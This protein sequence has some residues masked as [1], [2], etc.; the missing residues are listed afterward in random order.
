MSAPLLRRLQLPRELHSEA[1]GRR[2]WCSTAAGI[3]TGASNG[4]PTVGI[5]DP[6][7]WSSGRRASDGFL[8]AERLDDGLLVAET[9][10]LP[11]EPIVW[12]GDVAVSLGPPAEGG[13]PEPSGVPSA[14]AR[15]GSPRIRL[16]AVTPRVEVVWSVNKTLAQVECTLPCRPVGQRTFE[17]E[18][19]DP[20]VRLEASESGS[21][22]RV[23]P[24]AGLPPIIIRFNGEVSLEGAAVWHSDVNVLD[25]SGP[26]GVEDRFSPGVFV[27]R[28]PESAKSLR[29][30]VEVEA[31]LAHAGSRP[32]DAQAAPPT[33]R[34]RLLD[35]LSAPGLALEEGWAPDRVSG[36][37]D[38]HVS[39]AMSSIGGPGEIA[40]DD[41]AL[42]LGRTCQLLLR[43]LRSAWGP[44][45]YRGLVEDCFAPAIRSMVDA[46]LAA[47]PAAAAPAAAP[48]A[49]APAA[50]TPAAA[51]P[52][53][54][55]ASSAG[56]E[57]PGRTAAP[58]L[59]AEGVGELATA[60]GA[61]DGG[62]GDDLVP[63]AARFRGARRWYE[64]LASTPA[65]PRGA[66]SVEAGALLHQLFIF[67]EQ[68]CRMVS[69]GVRGESAASR[70]LEA[71]RW[72]QRAF[73]LSTP[74]RLADLEMD[75]V[76]PIGG[77]ALSMR[78]GMLVA[79][80]LE[81]APLDE[82]QR[83]AVVNAV[84]ERLLTPLGVRSIDR[85]DR[86]FR[87]ESPQDGA[88][89]P[90]LLGVHAEAAIRAFGRD[91]GR[92]D[93]EE[94]LLA[95]IDGAPEA[96]AESPGGGVT[97]IGVVTFP[98]ASG[99]SIRAFRLLTEVLGEDRPR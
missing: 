97:P 22:V 66:A 96:W 65:D 56:G 73:W 36:W 93:F 55:G 6:V 39:A 49:A 86:G 99:E 12:L 89:W 28:L 95:A 88:V 17:N 68:L 78:A 40:R 9:A 46:I 74:R 45:T 59:G 26:L 91:L 87:E 51:T 18:A 63:G 75:R 53:E 8:V 47:D 14:P 82:M 72:F 42:W 16:G 90:W 43:N 84:D 2:R 50:A 31:D 13:E 19:L 81:G 76:D 32:T 71:R 79:A 11:G 27:I 30:T 80:A 4:P 85:A 24:Y 67:E 20:R 58:D 3:S 33:T 7:L 29:M 38:Q 23:R 77:A 94:S 54:P 34:D 64:V 44:L 10:D 69:D 21:V 1:L 60:E 98:P 35:I 70:A 48:A 61:E 92:L 83:R 41:S 52:F 62:A 25:K 15:L 5:P 57:G 37:V